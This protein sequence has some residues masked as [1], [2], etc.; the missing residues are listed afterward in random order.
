[1][2]FDSVVFLIFLFIFLFLYYGLNDNY[3]FQN[4]LI[5]IGGFV[6]YGFWE[7]RFLGL[8]IFS[9]LI[10]F[11][12]SLLIASTSNFYK[13]KL[14]LITSI[15]FNIGIL[16]A[17]KYHGFFI[18]Q[19]NNF[20]SYNQILRTIPEY[21]I[22]L[23]L[24]IGISFYTFQ[25]LAYTID[26]YKGKKEPEKNLITY[27]AFVVFFPQ[28]V[29]GPIERSQKLLPQL[30]K[31]RYLDYTNLKKAFFLIVLGLFMKV[32]I[33]DN[34]APFVD[35]GFSVPNKNGALLFMSTLLF[36]IQIYCDF[37]GYS[38]IAI[39][40]GSALGIKL[41]TNFIAPYFSLSLTDFWRRWH[42]TLGNWFRDY[43]Y[44]PLGGNRK[45]LIRQ[46]LNLAIVMFLVGAWHGGNWNYVIWG[47][48]H[49]LFLAITAIYQKYVNF[50][51]PRKIGFL[52]RIIGWLL[53][54]TIVSFGW[55][56]FRS[57]DLHLGV[58]RLLNISYFSFDK[59]SLRFVNPF[60]LFSFII[61]IIDSWLYKI[62]N[63]KII[64]SLSYRNYSLICGFGIFC[65]YI[66]F[67]S[68]K[69]PFIYF[70]F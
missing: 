8:L 69:V 22:G 35:F 32:V 70:Q 44:I 61:F 58:E 30:K 14:L 57:L 7:I 5:A 36:G 18:E 66:Y 38:L 65:L 33:A 21:Y 52:R 55:Y 11:S 13:K 4:A 41:S 37:A 23:I 26:V 53:T 6:F 24:P 67:G 34:A 59:Y 64:D 54:M 28:L 47:I 46:S 51:F 2:S 42:I 25:T 15:F 43:V 49:G 1:M 27:T 20:V 17:F 3:K 48:W 68:A 62:P 50:E 63:F 10:D 16:V 60:L 39:G 31:P 45:G 19:F 40:L 12:I 9:C 29:A 56:I